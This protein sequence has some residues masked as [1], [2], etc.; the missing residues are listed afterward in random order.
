MIAAVSIIS[1]TLFH[2]H[3]HAFKR[4]IRTQWC[5]LPGT[6]RE[7]CN[8]FSGFPDEEVHDRVCN[9]RD[10][11][12]LRIK[13]SVVPMVDGVRWRS[14]YVPSYRDSKCPGQAPRGGPHRTPSHRSSRRE[15]VEDAGV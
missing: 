10:I 8:L 6:P 15:S 9:L 12:H 14:V 11:A 7:Y 4:L 1:T 13:R 2:L 3:S 5:V